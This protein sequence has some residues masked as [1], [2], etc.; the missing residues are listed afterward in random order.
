MRLHGLCLG[1]LGR[2]GVGKLRVG[3]VH[4]WD[5][6]ILGHLCLLDTLQLLHQHLL[7][8]LLLHLEVHLLLLRQHG[9]LLLLLLWRQLGG[10]AVVGCLGLHL[11]LLQCPLLLLPGRLLLLRCVPSR[12][13]VLLVHL[14]LL[15]R[16]PVLLRG[17]IVLG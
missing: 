6:A 10:D 15:H 4:R 17:G 3:V 7:L 11:L 8:H 13:H 2:L 1:R 14:L 5:D 9:L 12:L 16:C